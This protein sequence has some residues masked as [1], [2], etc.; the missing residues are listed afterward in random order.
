MYDTYTK[1]ELIDLV[2]KL[3]IENNNLK[4]LNYKNQK[5]N[6][7]F[8]DFINDWLE[9]HKIK[10]DYTTYNA[11]RMNLD[12]H[13]L[14]YFSNKEIYLS[15]ITAKD[16]QEYYS[17]KFSL[18]LSNNTILKHHANIRKALDYA[19]RIDLITSNPADKVDKPKKQKYNANFLNKEELQTL[20]D[21]FKR[22]S[23]Y[24]PVLLSSVLG[25]RRSEVLGL[26]WDNI[27]FKNKTVL[28][29]HSVVL[30]RNKGKQEIVF[31]DNLKNN[32]SIRYLNLPDLLIEELK[33]VKQK[34]IKEYMNNRLLYNK[35]YLKYICVTNDGDLIKPEYLTRKFK[36][37]IEENEFKKIRFH[38]LRHTSAS[39][40]Y[41]LGY[42]LKDIQEWLGHSNISTTG[43][44][45]AHIDMSRK[46]QISDSIDNILNF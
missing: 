39:I 4:L 28:I 45:Y 9:M 14:P 44:I 38:D 10:I 17:Y 25:L 15:T 6:I 36:E 40:I 13:I 42:G 30:T 19:Y 34:Q 46:K 32:S 11:Y 20:L 21:L 26:R 5:Q 27:D 35:K 31:K 1:Q 2:I 29:N 33:I 8:S 37:V 12:K 23:I 24:A 3:S 18:G 16:I 41:N 7:L 43:D 22:T